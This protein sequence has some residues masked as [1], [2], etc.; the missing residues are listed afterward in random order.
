MNATFFAALVPEHLLL[1]LLLA[2]MLLEM[3]RLDVGAGRLLFVL[4]MLAG[5]V[6]SSVQLAQG[7]TAVVVPGEIVVDRFA[8]QGRVVVLACAV[9][10]GIAFPS[11]ESFK[12]WLLAA[13]SALGALVILAS[14]G[15]ASLFLGIEMLSLPAFA[16]M[17]Q[18]RGS[19]AAPEAAFKYLVLSSVATALLLFGVS[20]AYGATGTLAIADWARLLPQ[21]GA[22]PK[23]AALLVLCG[24]FLKAA[25]FP[26]HG[27][28]PDAYA[29]AR[30][31]VT[32]LLASLVKAAVVLA[33]V[34]IVTDI[35]LD[36]GSAAVIGALAMVSIA[37]GNLAALAQKT[38]RRM[39]AYSSVAHAG[40]MV[41]ALLDTTGQRA[42]D[43][44]WYAA[45]YALVTL[46]AC[47]CAARLMPGDD[48][49]LARLDGAF[50][51]HPGTAVLFACALLSLAGLP[52]F[53]GFF[54]KL[55]VFRSVIASGYVVPAVIAF[56]ASFLGLAYYAGIAMRLFRAAPGR[57]T[58]AAPDAVAGARDATA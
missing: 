32:A 21:P 50:A 43:L 10:A 40:Y 47:A 22:L 39:L 5:L 51:V 49:D 11:R 46:V 30:L 8:L 31:P 12:F 38:F 41:F 7:Y 45:I 17:V 3:L 27:W 16:L 55:M 24:L 6:A 34:R 14:A 37:F 25:L 9:V 57:E 42:D 28:A 48:D 52:P 53:P 58:P 19:G 2:L 26:F 1:A 18:G 15:F 13:S 54:A 36:A 44:V 33:L 23:A 56:A 20:L 4:A 35:P 29:G